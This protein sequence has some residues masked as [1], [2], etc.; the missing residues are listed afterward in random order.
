MRSTDVLADMQDYRKNSQEYRDLH[1][2]QTEEVWHNRDSWGALLRAVTKI[3]IQCQGLCEDRSQKDSSH[4]SPLAIWAPEGF[5]N[6]R[7]NIIWSDLIKIK[8]F[9][10]SSNCYVWKNWLSLSGLGGRV[11][12]IC[13]SVLHSFPIYVWLSEQIVRCEDLLKCHERQKSVYVPSTV[14]TV[15]KTQ[16][17]NV[18]E[19]PSQSP[20]LNSI[21]HLWRELKMAFHQP[22]PAWGDL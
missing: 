11:V 22:Y 2:S 20:D 13:W 3:Q 5:S 21:D 17:V 18:L 10:L 6:W 15:N 4:C 16:L 7:S 14:I 9:G 1:I 19:W 8:L 12:L